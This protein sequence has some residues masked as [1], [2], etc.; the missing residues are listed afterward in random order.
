MS[1]RK[2]S[3]RL[4]A[5]FGAASTMVFGFIGCGPRADDINQ[6]QPG[7]VRKSIFEQDSEWYYRRTIVKSETTN[8]L[9]I[10]G[11]GDLPLERIKWRIEERHLV[12]Y[13]PYVSIP[14]SGTDE[15]EGTTDVR[16]PVLAVF[17]IVSHFDIIRGYD[18]TTGNETNIISENASDRTWDKR[19]Y[20]RVNFAID[21]I[22]GSNADNVYEFPVTWVTTAQRWAYL[23][24]EPTNT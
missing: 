13:K 4:L 2:A 17:P 23:D 16:G 12:A 19:E 14:G 5:L 22:A 21:E 15:Y 9:V 7:Y 11:S 20:M 10:E 1:G 8:A 18:S 24:S 3:G 6:V